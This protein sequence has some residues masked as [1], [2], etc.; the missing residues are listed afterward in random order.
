[1][2]CARVRA[3]LSPWLEG[4]LAPAE[5]ERVQSHLD[6]CPGCR[7]ELRALREGIDLL[8]G[9]DGAAGPPH[10]GLRVVARVR[11]AAASPP[12][13]GL[14]AAVTRFA[15]QL[16]VAGL[17]AGGAIALSQRML[18][19]GTRGPLVAV[20]DA[21]SQMGLSEPLG[22]SAPPAEPTAAELDAALD[23]GLV[24]A[25][26]LV[27]EWR[28]HRGAARDSWA[29]SLAARAHARGDAAMLAAALRGRPEREAV[30]L[31]D[32]LAPAP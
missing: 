1:M 7:G 3:R 19:D 10:L 13:R 4:D 17:V 30:A 8:R 18:S 2:R 14:P 15:A 21:G 9:L 23:R 24:D 16:A 12:P 29:A 5:R 28:E 22:A 11:E 6:G 20:D 27:R 31:A 32:R 26:S 25:G